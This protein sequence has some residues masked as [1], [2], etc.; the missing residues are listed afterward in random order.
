MVH[1]SDASNNRKSKGKR[2]GREKKGKRKEKGTWEKDAVG[3]ILRKLF[4][5]MMETLEIKVGEGKRKGKGRRRRVER[6]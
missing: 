2:K 6:T 1:N 3:K 4:W 5:A